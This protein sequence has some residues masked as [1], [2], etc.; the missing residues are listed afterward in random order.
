MR[1]VWGG[2]GERLARETQLICT[3]SH[4]RGCVSN[5]RVLTVSLVLYQVLGC[6]VQCGYI[7][8]GQTVL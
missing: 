2:H 3:L 1:E 5:G 8:R 6:L 7:T 4:R